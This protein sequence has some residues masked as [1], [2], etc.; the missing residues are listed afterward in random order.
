MPKQFAY[1]FNID[2][3][4]NTFR[5]ESVAK[6]VKIFVGYIRRFKKILIT[7]TISSRL[8][9]PIGTG[10]KIIFRLA[11]FLKETLI[12]SSHYAANMV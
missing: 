6:N 12:K 7:F 9:V 2:S 11:L 5:S 1:S 8:N 3:A 4:A 10:Q